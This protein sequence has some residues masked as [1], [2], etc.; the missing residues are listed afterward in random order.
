MA[1]EAAA[2]TKGQAAAVAAGAQAEAEAAAVAVEGAAA[3]YGM[4]NAG[5][6]SQPICTT[7]GRTDG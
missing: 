7:R 4:V 3:G 6:G 2:T 1:V 5:Y